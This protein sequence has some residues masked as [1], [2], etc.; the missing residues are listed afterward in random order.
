VKLPAHIQI[1]LLYAGAMVI[2]LLIGG[3]GYIS[4]RQLTAT[5]DSAH[6]SQAVLDTLS[7]LVDVTVAIDSAQRSGARRGSQASELGALLAR[8]DTL[9]TALRRV[10]GADPADVAT[11]DTLAARMS[12]QRTALSQG[13][14]P[15]ASSAGGGAVRNRSTEELVAGIRRA[16]RRIEAEQGMVL[17][18]R[19]DETR[20]RLRISM[21]V[22]GIAFAA[23]FALTAVATFRVEREM[24]DRRAAE[25]KALEARELAEAASRTKSDF[26]ASISH[27]LRTPLNS[28]IGFA[29]V[30]LKNRNGTLGDQELL[31]LQRIRDN[32]THQLHLIDDLLDLS[33]IEAGKQR[34]VITSVSLEELVRDTVGQLEGR[35][36]SKEVVLRVDLPTR[37]LPVETDSRKL[38]Q[39]LINLVGNALKF[40]PTG[41]VRVSVQV[42]PTTLRPLRIDVTDT[43]IGIPANRLEAIF[44][45]FEQVENGMSQKGTGLGLTIARSLCH[46]MGYRLTVES[47]VGKGSTFSIHLETAPTLPPVEPQ[48]APAP[49]AI[50]V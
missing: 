5:V 30:L 47:E 14:S 17:R 49:E 18:Q 28:I 7:Q 33:A 35:V 39:V 45:P 10:I 43:G 44:A 38:R 16:A 48:P 24:A 29:N 6:Q 26:L 50:T 40:T 36:T 13:A 22:L 32:G 15:T 34:L 8:V 19:R 42:S 9:S 46:L 3:M 12:E 27:E 11:L 4:T 21:L 20:V 23:A 41:S 37:M 1:R 25:L 2:L 31:F